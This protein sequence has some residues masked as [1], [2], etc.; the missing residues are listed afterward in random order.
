MILEKIY[1]MKDVKKQ[2]E[3]KVVIRSIRT[4]LSKEK[5]KNRNEIGVLAIKK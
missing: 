5:I 1:T 2:K 3:L 4:E